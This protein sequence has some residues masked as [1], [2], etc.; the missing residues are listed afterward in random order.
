MPDLY[1]IWFLL[2]GTLLAGYAILDG[3]DL[4]VGILHLLAPTDHDRR[5]FLNSIGPIWDGNEVWLVVFGGA[6]F[7]AFPNAYAT[8]FSGFYLA[9]IALL[10]ALIFRAVSIEFRSKMQ[11]AAWRRIWDYGFFASSLLASLLF[12]IAVGNSMLGIPLDARG[13]FI[14]S[15]FDLLH[16]YALLAGCVVA[17]MFAMHGSIYLYLKLPDGETRELVRGWMWHTWGIFLVFYMLGTF[18]TVARVPRALAN[19]DRFPWAPAVVVLSVL[20]IANIP[21]SVYSGKP[22]QAFASSTIAITSLVGLFG[23]ALFPNLV[24]ASNVPAYSLTVRTAAS[25]PG[26]LRTMLIFALIGMPF[27][28]VYS[29]VVYRAFHGRVRLGDHSY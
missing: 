7:A 13:D 25:S 20:A 27:V 18:Y 15:F 14:G 8:I 29:A 24:S 9:L 17:A 3:F 4:G 23:L 21:R 10:F 11:S 16:P 12:G 5:L 1:T 2:L 6:M 26:T 28:L 19:F 22:V